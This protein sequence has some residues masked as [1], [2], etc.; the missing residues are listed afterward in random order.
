M[1]GVGGGGDEDRRDRGV[2]AAGKGQA[3]EAGGTTGGGV[4]GANGDGTY[5]HDAAREA[6]LAALIDRWTAHMRWRD[7]FDRW[8]ERRLWQERGQ[9]GRLRQLTELCGT[10]AGRP[11]LD[12]GCGM[13]GLAV[14][15]RRADARVV[16]HDPNRAAAAR[17]RR[18]AA[19]HGLPPPVAA[20]A[21][22]PWPSRPGAFDPVA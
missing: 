4:L 11:V 9:D 5:Q 14:T 20:R 8:R 21:G 1:Q 17:G 13:G 18:R 16:G 15:L 3:A 10:L 6:Q 19:R 12:L 2:R 22:Q 7:D